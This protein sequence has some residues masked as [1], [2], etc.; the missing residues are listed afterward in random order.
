MDRFDELTKT[1]A[2]STSRRQALKVLGGSLAGGLL[3]ALGVGT[4]DAEECKRD[5]KA[6]KKGTQC[7]SG[8]CQ[9][10]QCVTPCT[11][12]GGT[13]SGNSDC[14]SGNC[15]NGQCC[16]SGRTN[17]NGQCV[18]TDGDESNCGTCGNVCPEPPDP[19]QGGAY[20][21]EGRCDCCA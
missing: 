10:G 4:A 14:C 16:P 6:C 19:S 9:N 5:G 21:L 3:A 11:T 2:Q 20:C 17:C 1:L 18:D 12:D 7:C 15:S 13:C 8:V